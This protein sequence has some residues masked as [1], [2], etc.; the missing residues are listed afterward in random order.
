[1]S[2]AFL[3][4]GQGAQMVGMCA[5]L[6][7][8][9]PSI[10]LRIGEGSDAL[11]LD[12]HEL[13]RR[14][15]PRDLAQT[16]VAQVAIYCLSYG[17]YELLAERG[18]SPS[19]V[20]GHSLGQFTAYAAAGA[21]SFGTGLKLV[22]A[23]GKFMHEVNQSIDGSMLAVSGLEAKSLAALVER[24]GEGVWIANRNAP[25]Q[26]VLAG[27]RESLRRVLDQV[28]EMG[29]R[30]TWLDVAGPYHTPLFETAA[31]KF[32]EVVSQCDFNNPVVP[33][34]ANSSATAINQREQVVAE[35]HRHML[36]AVDW[37]GTMRAFIV[38]AD[39]LLVEVGPGRVL[40][41][42]ALRNAP[43]LKC[44]SVGSLREFE[45]TC[46]ALQETCA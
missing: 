7:K 27:W 1:M 42:L 30:G 20:A 11:G 2:V 39:E 21:V 45:S 32:S 9:F 10:G 35:T 41:G 3:F 31:A 19:V 23:R 44:L 17:I 46:L 18:L 40:K 13:I 14:G 36:S 15:P 29:G 37:T 24:G 33:I 28:A 12:L 4:P 16:H 25:S 5:D 43:E 6:I 34:I 8:A 26:L 22:A 38:R